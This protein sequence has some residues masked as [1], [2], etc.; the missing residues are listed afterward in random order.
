MAWK[1]WHHT[2]EARDRIGAAARARN[3]AA[4]ANAARSARSQA[5]KALLPKK[6]Q[7]QRKTAEELKAVNVRRA[8]EWARKNPEKKKIIARRYYERNRERL[9]AKQR[10]KNKSDEHKAFRR[11]YAPK[12]R[13]KNPDLYAGYSE[14]RRVRKLQAPGSHTTEQWLEKVAQG[15]G[16]CAYCGEAR[17]LARDH[18]VPLARGGSHDIENIVPACGPCNSAKGTLTGEE[19]RKRRAGEGPSQDPRWA[20]QLAAARAR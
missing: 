1:G 18:D 15:G 4:I 6:E 7:R 19:F 16:R 14:R 12:H 13:A 20:A 17:R 2:Q 3:S 10:E 8:V 5:A 11:E 9:N